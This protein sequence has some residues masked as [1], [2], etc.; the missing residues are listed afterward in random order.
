MNTYFNQVLKEQVKPATGCTEPVAIALA[1]AKAASLISGEIQSLHI[2]ASKGL[3]KNASA[4]GIPGTNEKGIGMAAFMGVLVK[5]PEMGMRILEGASDA[6]KE[7][8]RAY[9]KK[10]ILELGYTESDY[11]VYVKATLKTSEGEA[12]AIIGGSHDRFIHISVN[13]QIL[14]QD[15]DGKSGAQEVDTEDT[16]MAMRNVTIAQILDFA[17]SVPL[18]NIA[19]LEESVQMNSKI[20]ALGQ[21]EAYGLGIG[22][23]LKQLVDQDMLCNDLL[24]KIRIQVSAAA[25]AR[26]G[27]AKLPVM[28]SCG[29]GN[30]GILIT[31]PLNAYCEH[32][33]KSQEELLRSLAIANLTNAL[34]KSYLGKLSP[35]CG[36]SVSAGL[37][38]A[39]GLSWLAGGS[40]EQIEGA[41]KGMIANLT[42]TLCDGAKGTCALKLETAAVEAFTYAMM[43]VNG[44]Y[45]H[46][47]Q[48][49]V[50]ESTEASIANL[51]A[52]S[53]QGMQRMDQTV[54]DMLD[55]RQN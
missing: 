11:D 52:V 10:N 31:L 12:T 41:I 35:L 50:E 18:E 49:I 28:T 8:A 5:K 14:Q 51:E 32:Y 39:A 54:L 21:K 29:S 44:V 48:G 40:L 38:A 20:S 47:V 53:N 34:A 42:G 37:G 2:V 17:I 30:Q 36:C 16:L 26:M 1:C 43:S 7:E 27:G 46:D 23:G 9:V 22:R 33:S 3:Y 25:D 6:E 13:G 45:L 4:V 19:W 24:T 15:G 55:H